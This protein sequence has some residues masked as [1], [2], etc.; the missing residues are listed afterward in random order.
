MEQLGPRVRV[1]AAIPLQGFKV[2]LTFDNDARREVDLEPYL[3][4]PIFE[5]M[6]SDPNRFRSM[7][8]AGGT[9][10]WDNVSDW[11]V[12]CHHRLFQAHP[13]GHFGCA[14]PSS[15]WS[16]KKAG[17]TLRNHIA[18]HADR[19][20]DCYPPTAAFYAWHQQH[21]QN[22]ACRCGHR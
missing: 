7:M 4:G 12:D 9:L 21:R 2:L 22:R 15:E 6:R 13:S 3:R 16:A 1:C 8:I 14:S 20:W 18:R 5:P 19:T 11:P 10:A 17:A